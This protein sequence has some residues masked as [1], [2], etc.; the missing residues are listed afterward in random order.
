MAHT[1]QALKSQFMSDRDLFR[2][3]ARVDNSTFL[4]TI[5]TLAHAENDNGWPLAMLEAIEPRLSRGLHAWTAKDFG[6]IRKAQEQGALHVGTIA[7]DLAD[8]IELL[9]KWNDSATH[10]SKDSTWFERLSAGYLELRSF[11][12]CC[13]PGYNFA[14]VSHPRARLAFTGLKS[15]RLIG[16]LT[17]ENLEREVV[18]L[19]GS[20][21]RVST[22][23]MR[24]ATI[25]LVEDAT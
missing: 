21:F 8:T 25:H 13:A 12:G 17:R 9:P 1:Y 2:A 7:Q 23:D 3:R 18:L 20:R 11:M 19:P 24:T 16:A 5:S 14:Y 22:V 6:A 4:A 15:A 10:V